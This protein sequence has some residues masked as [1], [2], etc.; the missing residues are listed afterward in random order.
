MRFVYH[1]DVNL[2]PFD[3]KEVEK[4]LRDSGW[5]TPINRIA[6]VPIQGNSYLASICEPATVGE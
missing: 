4:E 6:F 5:L 3:Q 1:Y 2:G